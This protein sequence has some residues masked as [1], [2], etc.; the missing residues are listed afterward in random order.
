[1]PDRN[2]NSTD[3]KS[4][5]DQASLD[6]PGIVAAPDL[7]DE[8]LKF[9]Y[10]DHTADVRV[11]T[12]TKSFKNCLCALG[13]GLVNYMTDLNSLRP[14]M[15]RNISVEADSLKLAI[16]HFL[17]EVLFLYGSEYFMTC[18]IEINRL[19]IR[20]DLLAQGGSVEEQDDL[21]VGQ[22]LTGTNEFSTHDGEIKNYSADS[23]AGLTASNSPYVIHATCW[24]E[25]FDRELH[26]QGTEVK[27]ITMHF[28]TLELK[29]DRLIDCAVLLDI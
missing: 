23:D 18:R 7:D 24:G 1:M 21:I 14:K 3:P 25:I 11:R 20:R 29:Q 5:N 22:I 9:K 15:V 28:M 2:N 13:L 19:S 4:V 10:E 8:C 17:D 26:Q 6:I 27:A 16:F 12:E